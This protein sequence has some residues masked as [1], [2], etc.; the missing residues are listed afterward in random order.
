MKHKVLV[1]GKIHQAGLDLLKNYDHFDLILDDDKPK[2]ILDI[3][4][5]V[6]AII[7]RMT[8]INE[9]LIKNS[10]NLKIVSRHGVGLRKEIIPIGIE[11][12][13]DIID[14]IDIMDIID[15]YTHQFLKILY[16]VSI[17]SVAVGI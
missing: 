16:K 9:K 5:D 17:V 6:N 13:T 2:N 12:I 4:K 15:I 14:I 8:P 11:R 1:L 7:V 3:T 10:K